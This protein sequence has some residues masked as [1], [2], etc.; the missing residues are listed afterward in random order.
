MAP[1]AVT[2]RSR[3][4]QEEC[5]CA[6]V[7]QGGAIRGLLIFADFARSAPSS[8]PSTRTAGAAVQAQDSCVNAGRVWHRE[9]VPTD[10]D[11]V[12]LTLRFEW[13]QEGRVGLDEI[14]RLIFPR[15]TTDAGLYRFRLRS[16]NRATSTY[17]GE[18]D[19]LARRMTHY[20]SPGPSQRTNLRLNA[21]L[22]EALANEVLV[23]L[24]TVQVAQILIG[25]SWGRQ[26]LNLRPARLLAENA[27]LLNVKAE[28]TPVLNL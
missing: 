7:P 26:D 14:G 6:F 28:G 1:E 27:A 12:D 24:A 8:R 22:R 13:K 5:L 11:Q 25:E 20:R 17:L 23:E 3:S 9:A 21:L 15:L 19:N 18:S 2:S 16:G 10:R 4:E